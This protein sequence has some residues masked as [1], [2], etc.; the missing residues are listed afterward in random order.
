MN[1]FPLM[2][3]CSILFVIGAGCVNKTPEV[4]SNII[5]DEVKNM[6]PITM[7]YAFPG[8]LDAER[9]DNKQVRLETEKGTIVFE[10]YADTAPKTVS[11]F[12]YL[13][14]EGY[15]DGLTFHRRV[16]N[17]VIQGGDPQGTG[18]GGPGYRFED[19]LDDAY[20]YDRGIVAMANAGP[21]T[22]GSQFFIML[23][24]TPLPKAYSIFGRVTEGIDVI[25]SILI[26]D[27]MTKVT[28]E[29][30]TSE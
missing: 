27:K 3:L 5:V 16:E 19:E 9:I 1:Y 11:N 25:D 15:F 12:V 20:A 24:D 28:I 23:A 30:K 13:A 14:D 4:S 10:L 26:G 8:T 6:K 17:F 29:E 22:N 18:T 21:D 7:T 2:G